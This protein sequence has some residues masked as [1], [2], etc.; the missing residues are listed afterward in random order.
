MAAVLGKRMV[1]Y[2]I[3]VSSP[4]YKGSNERKMREIRE[5][6]SVAK[7]LECHINGVVEA[8]DRGLF[9]FSYSRLA[10]DLNVPRDDVRKLLLPV[11]GGHNGVTVEKR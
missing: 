8:G 1:E 3:H 7:K 4:M 5:L 6:A 10:E 9:Q 11:D 2:P